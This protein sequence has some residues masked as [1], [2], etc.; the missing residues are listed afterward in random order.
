MPTKLE[1]STHENVKAYHQQ[2]DMSKYLLI[3]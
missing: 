1:L 2:I 3:Y